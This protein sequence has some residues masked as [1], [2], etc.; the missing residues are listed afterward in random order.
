L[1]KKKGT[2][3]PLQRMSPK[4]IAP[5]VLASWSAGG[6]KKK[7]GMPSRDARK[8]WP[9]KKK[10]SYRPHLKKGAPLTAAVRRC[11]L[12]CANKERKPLISLFTTCFNDGEGRELEN[13]C[14]EEG[15][16]REGATPVRDRRKKGRR[17]RGEKK[18][19]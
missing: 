7:K 18:K 9:S 17:N 6:P 1:R 13:A 11:S 12:S 10:T 5:E 16:G 8:I 14:T 19:N 3:F 15:G 4:G 2:Y